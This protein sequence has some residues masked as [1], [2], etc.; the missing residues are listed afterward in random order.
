MYLA[1][2]RI[3][4]PEEFEHKPELKSGLSN[5]TVALLLAQ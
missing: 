2:Y 4:P 5:D 3:I 1:S